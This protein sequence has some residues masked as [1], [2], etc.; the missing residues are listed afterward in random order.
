MSIS[1]KSL[2]DRVERIRIT[3]LQSYI[4]LTTYSNGDYMDVSLTESWKNFQVLLFASGTQGDTSTDSS[5]IPLRNCALVLTDIFV[6]NPNLQ[7]SIT[8]SLSLPSAKTE[9]ILVHAISD[10]K[11]RYT[12]HATQASNEDYIYA[13]YGLKLYYS[14]SY[15]IIYRATH[16]LE[17]IF[18]CLKQ[19]RC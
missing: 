17:K 12:I 13:V 3:K 15:N 1:L 8:S 14:F 6:D 5:W 16:L 4:A 7:W 10:T 19:R 2:H 11:L 9:S 18:L